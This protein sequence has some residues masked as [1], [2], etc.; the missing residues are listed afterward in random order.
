MY[1]IILNQTKIQKPYSASS[2]LIP[3][4]EAV[5]RTA[6]HCGGGSAP[7]RPV[8]AL[9]EVNNNNNMAEGRESIQRAAEQ[10]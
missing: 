6:G 9:I 8:S 2:V 4:V 1:H 5:L 10:P 3:S 7:L